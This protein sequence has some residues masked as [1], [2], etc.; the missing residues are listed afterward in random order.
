MLKSEPGLLRG[1]VTT[2]PKRAERTV[3]LDTEQASQGGEEGKER[4]PNTEKNRA[5]THGVGPLF[6]GPVLTA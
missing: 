1:W 5:N 6:P 4:Q 3:S 2:P